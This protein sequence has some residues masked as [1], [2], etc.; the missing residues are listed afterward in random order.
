MV[1]FFWKKQINIF[2]NLNQI[3]I[4]ILYKRI[5]IRFFQ[6]ISVSLI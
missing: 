4:H 6:L 3:Y 2:N 5:V 1:V